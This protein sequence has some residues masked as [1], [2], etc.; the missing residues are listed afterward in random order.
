MGSTLLI[1]AL[2]RET[3]AQ[4]SSV[5]NTVTGVIPVSYP[6]VTLASKCQAC[7]HQTPPLSSVPGAGNP[8]CS[9]NPWWFII[10]H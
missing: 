2:Q 8:G 6:K 10:S 9:C 5:T 7:Q 1:P 4:R 3:E